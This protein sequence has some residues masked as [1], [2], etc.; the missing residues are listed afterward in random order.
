MVAQLA[1]NK[2]FFFELT[3][4]FTLA[5]NLSGNILIQLASLQ[6]FHHDF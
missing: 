6:G 4:E 1:L 5:I 3:I 2:T